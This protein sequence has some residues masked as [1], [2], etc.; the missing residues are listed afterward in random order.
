MT[1]TPTAAPTAATVP[2]P[3][4]APEMLIPSSARIWVVTGFGLTMTGVFGAAFWIASSAGWTASWLCGFLGTL[5]LS[6][7][8]LGQQFANDMTESGHP[9]WGK[10]IGIAAFFIVGGAEVGV[11]SIQNTHALSVGHLWM[12]VACALL[13]AANM[14]LLFLLSWLSARPRTR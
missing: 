11:F 10:A 2:A 4:T 13:V 12:G 6:G 1:V 9:N 5:I 8:Y 3:T 14:G 7:V